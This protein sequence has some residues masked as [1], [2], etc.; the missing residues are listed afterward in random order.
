MSI[1]LKKVGENGRFIVLLVKQLYQKLLQARHKR[2]K[3]YN[4]TMEN[5]DNN[6]PLE[7][8]KVRDFWIEICLKGSTDV[9]KLIKMDDNGYLRIYFA[10]HQD[11]KAYYLYSVL[12]ELEKAGVA[13]MGYKEIL[14]DTSGKTTDIQGQ[15]AERIILSSIVDSQMIWIRK[16]T[17][18]LTELI[19]FKSTDTNEYFRHYLLVN[20][21]RELNGI[22]RDSEEFFGCTNLN[23]K[24]QIQETIQK[25]QQIETQLKLNDCWYLA[26]KK[27]GSKHPG[28][29]A[30]LS[31]FR[32]KLMLAMKKANDDQKLSLGLTY[33]Q[34]YG[35]SSQS[36]HPAFSNPD[37]EIDVKDIEIG[38]SRIGILAAHILVMSRSLLKDR[39]RK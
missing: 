1:F 16:F 37:P 10:S 27:G 21:L 33:D 20:H 4:T 28:E 31:Q 36:L 3:A 26:D 32:D 2:I 38:M 39:R 14:K 23:Y 34:L 17:E 29:K 22:M 9:K 12:D 13:L 7:E 18:I 5:D 11:S 8:E 19:L 15:H 24:H 35:K 25:I 30:K 6:P